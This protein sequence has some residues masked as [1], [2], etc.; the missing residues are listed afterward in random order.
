VKAEA[1]PLKRER[2]FV[3]GLVGKRGDAA[4]KKAAGV[5][6]RRRACGTI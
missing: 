3:I 2:K 1:L 4:G 6:T 5:Q